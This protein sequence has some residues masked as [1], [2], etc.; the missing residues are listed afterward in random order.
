V[1]LFSYN[2]L[3]CGPHYTYAV[4]IEVTTQG[5]VKKVNS[6]VVYKDPSEDDLCFEE[7]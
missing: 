1:H 5:E 6:E 2:E 7:H 4:D 3:G